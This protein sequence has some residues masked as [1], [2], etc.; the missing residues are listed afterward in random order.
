MKTPIIPIERASE[1][2]ITALLDAGILVIGDDNEIHA[3]QE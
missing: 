1:D 2:I 3:V